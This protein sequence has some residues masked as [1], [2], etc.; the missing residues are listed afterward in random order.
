MDGTRA[1]LCSCIAEPVY[2]AFTTVS[3]T[4]FDAFLLLDGRVIHTV[5]ER[6]DKVI[7]GFR[8][9]FRDGPLKRS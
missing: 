5:Y 6:S 4:T 9:A 7:L 2:G 8:C 3:C 1:L